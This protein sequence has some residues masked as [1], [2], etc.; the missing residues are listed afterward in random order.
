ME[1]PFEEAVVAAEDVKSLIKPV[2]FTWEGSE[3]TLD[4][5]RASV[6]CAERDFDITVKT[7]AEQKMT[8][9]DDV[10][11][12]ALLTRQPNMKRSVSDRICWNMTNKAELYIRLYLLFANAVNTLYEEPDEG[13][14]ISWK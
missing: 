6:K 1:E 7:F 2:T 8:V 3:Y 10:F 9:F 12:C 5:N 13:N 11:Y 14:A 4:F